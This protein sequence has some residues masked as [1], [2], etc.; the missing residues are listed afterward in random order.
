MDEDRL[1]ALSASFRSALLEDTLPF[2]IGHCVDRKHGGF[3]TFV[4]RRGEP[5]C[6]DKGGWVQGRFTWL[7][8]RLYNSLEKRLEWLD[9]SR[10]G[11]EFIERCGFSPEG[12]VYFTLTREGHPL[13]LRRYIFAETFAAIAFAEYGRAA[14]DGERI[15]RAREIMELVEDILSN[16]EALP[17]KF[18]P[19]AFQ[20][21]SHAVAMIRVATYQ[22]LREADPAG[23][24]TYDALIDR[25]IDEIFTLFLKPD[26]KA[27]LETV[28]P[29]GET[30][31]GPVGRCVNPGHAIETSWFLMTEARTRR[32]HGLLER[33]L[34]ILDWS[35]ELGWDRVHGGLFSFVDVEGRQPEQV[36]WDMK[37]W[38][39]HTEAI[40]ATLL[41]YALTGRELYAEWFER[42]LDWSL[43]HFPDREQGEWF[44]YLHRDGTV[45]LDLK[46]NNWK[47]PFHL[48]RAQLYSHLLLEEMITRGVPLGW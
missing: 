18:F 41:A 27:L 48:P 30:L 3:A 11:I 31:E 22:V 21:R 47:G 12:R 19:R 45:A 8:A 16:P 25:S 33:A 6:G 29:A 26:R 7:L 10:H 13:R 34:P 39:P 1:R 43:A 15:A 5:L 28:G 14:G 32:D 24:A 20:A 40:Y 46:G 17:P 4:D 38:W 42:V 23:V 37:Y 36:E 44:G 2:W 9:L 35:L